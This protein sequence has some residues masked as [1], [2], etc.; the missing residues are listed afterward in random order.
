MPVSLCGVIGVIHVLQDIYA[1]PPESLA[2]LACWHMKITF[3]LG[4]MMG[5]FSEA[6]ADCGFILHLCVNGFC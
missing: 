1:E 4:Y 6:S 3:T 2:N 5:G